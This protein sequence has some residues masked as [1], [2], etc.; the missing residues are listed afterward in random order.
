MNRR[1]HPE[2]IRKKLPQLLSLQ[3]ISGI[4]RISPWSE[5]P[6][7]FCVSGPPA[8]ACQARWP[9]AP[10]ITGAPMP[11]LHQTEADGR[12]AETVRQDANRVT[13]AEAKQVW[14]MLG[15]P[16]SRV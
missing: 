12:A 14:V 5:K 4:L 13:P 15:K 7:A 2:S 11:T 6:R 8:L 1:C 9:T 10:F 3:P 16:G